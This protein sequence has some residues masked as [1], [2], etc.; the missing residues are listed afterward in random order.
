MSSVLKVRLLDEQVFELARAESR[1]MTLEK[2]I[3]I[4]LE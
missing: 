2:A 4:A 1:R 3:A